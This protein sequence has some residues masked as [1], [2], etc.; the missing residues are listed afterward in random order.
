LPGKSGFDVLKEMKVVAPGSLFVIISG[1]AEEELTDGIAPE[2]AFS[3]IT[4][5]F[6]VN[7]IQNTVARILGAV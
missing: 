6:T 4:K 5:P 7:Q 3:F 2:C 1:R